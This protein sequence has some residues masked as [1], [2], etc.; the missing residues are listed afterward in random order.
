MK[1]IDKK[2]LNFVIL[3]E[4]DCVFEAIVYYL[5]KQKAHEFFIKNNIKIINEL[6]FINAY[7]V[8]FNSENILKTASQK[9]VYYI[10]SVSSV[11]TQM[12]TSKEI[13]GVS[14]C[15]ETGKNISIA[16]IDTGVC[17][18]LDFCLGKNRILKFCDFVNS[19]NLPYDD[20]G[21]GTFVSG[22]ACGSGLM[23]NKK[24]SGIAH[25][26]N[27]ISLKA[28]DYRGEANAVKILSA[29]EW[30]FDNY[31]K[32]NICTV[33]MS[34]GSEP[35]GTHDPIMKGA[36]RLW[37]EGI[38]VVCAG[39]NSGPLAQTIKS[40]G[41]SKKII[42]VGGLKD[43][44][45]DKGEYSFKKFEIADF[46]SRG[47][48]LGRI[49]PDLIAPSVDIISCD[50]HGGYKKMSGTSVATPMVAGVCA[51]IKEK[52]PNA[53]PDQIKKFLLYNAK[54]INKCKYEQGYGV[55][56]FNIN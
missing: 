25:D 44:R 38:V 10:S 41:I 32:Y 39:G 15:I 2:L 45:N 20:N 47:P 12:Q 50:N 42:T 16:I 13:I 33:C 56:N 21:H 53:T 28:L 35:L 55:V 24:L 17:P 7:V 4:K 1:K 26:S 52:F 54:S 18:H 29:M 3:S 19:K 40:P 23:S 48:A 9:F 30:V 37:S 43:N 8:C 11:L 34:F 14:N 5:N 49:K 36:E 31:K 51:L 27:I 6:N 22:V 46:S